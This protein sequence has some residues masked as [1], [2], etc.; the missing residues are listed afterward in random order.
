M[1]KKTKYAESLFGAQ[2]NMLD[3]WILGVWVYLQGTKR[4]EA[5]V[6]FLWVKN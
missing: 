4:Y 1:Y 6:L 5:L 3:W 2:N